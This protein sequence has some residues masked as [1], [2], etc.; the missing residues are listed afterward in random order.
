MAVDSAAASGFGGVGGAKSL[1]F[2][3]EASL[4]F[5]D[6]GLLMPRRLPALTTQSLPLFASESAEPGVEERDGVPEWVRAVI[7]CA[8]EAAVGVMYRGRSGFA[9]LF[10]WSDV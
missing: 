10:L 4:S 1:D 8:C 3:C 2:S 6:F 5:R 9:M 7:D